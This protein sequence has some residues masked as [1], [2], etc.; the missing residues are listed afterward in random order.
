MS[1][2]DTVRRPRLVGPRDWE[3]LVKRGFASLTPGARDFSGRLLRELHDRGLG[4]P[5]TL[6]AQLALHLGPGRA[7][8]ADASPWSVVDRRIEAV[9]RVEGSEPGLRLA[10]QPAAC[11]AYY[12]ERVV[13]PLLGRL[14]RPETW[15]FA[16]GELPTPERFADDYARYEQSLTQRLRVLEPGELFCRDRAS[17]VE[18][19]SRRGLVDTPLPVSDTVG[20][21][22]LHRLE[23]RWGTRA[24]H[25]PVRRPLAPSPRR[26]PLHRNEGGVDGIRLSHRLEDLSSMLASERLYPPLLRL[27]RL[28]HSGYFVLRRPPRR[29]TRRDTL[30]VA[31]L[32]PLGVVS[33]LAVALARAA[34]F[35]A[36]LRLTLRLLRLGQG[37]SE[38]IWIETDGAGRWREQRFRLRDFPPDLPLPEEPNALFRR[39]FLALFDWLPTF[40]DDHAEGRPLPDPAGVGEGPPEAGPRDWLRAVW[41]KIEDDPRWRSDDERFAAGGRRGAGRRNA[42]RRGAGRRKAERRR[43][44][45]SARSS[46][47]L[48]L[49]AF[50]NR[51]V[52]VF[53][54]GPHRSHGEGLYAATLRSAL[55]LRPGGPG[56]SVVW[57]PERLDDLDSRA[58][59]AFTE[60]GRTVGLVP[61]GSGADDPDFE[62]GLAGVLG[63]AWIE[64]VLAGVRG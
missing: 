63:D 13:I 42:G 30:V 49:D 51:Q 52:M 38:L 19:L 61:S 39:D 10:F 37:R 20:L 48:D 62:H 9:W 26:P 28:L 64:A 14:C 11:P 15:L 25:S 12:L 8:G 56:L 27:E 7:P 53:A 43:E 2:R 34:W 21:A 57:L 40:L 55:G 29:E 32:P 23:P 47:P 35:H 50:A 5:P 33:P 59:W 18:S 22:T 24:P 60:G 36:M 3:P 45:G 44:E 4:I 17:T 58:G 31:L 54:P 6:A 1:P 16:E 46:R 41:G